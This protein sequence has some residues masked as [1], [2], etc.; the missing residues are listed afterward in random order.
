MLYRA[1]NFVAAATGKRRGEILAVR[2]ADIQA[3][4]LRYTLM[5]SEICS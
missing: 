5:N 2:D 3:R 4:R 1:V